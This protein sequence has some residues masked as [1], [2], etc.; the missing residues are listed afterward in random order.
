MHL[1]AI[2]IAIIVAYLVSTVVIGYWVSHR[3]SQSMQN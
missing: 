3:A 1:H 2:D